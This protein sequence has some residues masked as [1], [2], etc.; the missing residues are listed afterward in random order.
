VQCSEFNEPPLTVV[1]S[2]SRLVIMDTVLVR[3]LTTQDV[4]EYECQDA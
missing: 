1:E 3:Y 2:T 4:L